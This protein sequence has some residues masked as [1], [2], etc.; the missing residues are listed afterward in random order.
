MHTA[1]RWFANNS[2]AANLLMIVLV[3]GGISGA[4]TTNQEEFPNFD[5]KVINVFVP[6]LGAAPV[7]AEKAVCIRIEEAIEGVEGIEKVYGTAIEGGCS[8]ASQLYSDADDITATNEIKSRV[9]SINNLPIETEKPNVSKVAFTRRVLQIAVFG[10]ATESELKELGRSL[11]DKIA[12][13]EGIS[14]VAVEY[15]RPYEISIEVSEETLRRYQLNLQQVA[16]AIRT[17]ALDMPGGTLKTENGE[18]LIRTMGQAYLGEEFSD[19]VVLTRLDGTRVTLGE[20]ADIKDTFEEGDLL[21]AFNGA[22]AVM[23]NVSQVGSEDLIKIAAGHQR[24][25]RRV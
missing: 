21:A 4:L 7:E 20:I 16:Q 9:D 10:D 14:Q 6:Y 22:P 24:N 23:V 5:I 25:R 15:T 3:L 12:A 1:I 8:V 17:G 2:V 13:K 19:I 18:I 11:R